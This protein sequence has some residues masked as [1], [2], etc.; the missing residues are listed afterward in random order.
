MRMKCGQV[1]GLLNLDACGHAICLEPHRT[2]KTGLTL[3]HT[4]T[5]ARSISTK[6]TTLL[7][8]SKYRCRSL[9]VLPLV[10]SVTQHLLLPRSLMAM[11]LRLQ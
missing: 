7:C 6:F 1:V 3:A 9:F 8:M 10:Y 4:V 2:L 5:V 11:S